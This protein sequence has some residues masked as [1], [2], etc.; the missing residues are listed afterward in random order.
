MNIEEKMKNIIVA[1]DFSEESERAV[2][3]AMALIDRNLDTTIH[4]IHVVKPY[5]A[6]IGDTTGTTEIL[7]EEEEDILK[8]SRNRIERMV[9]SLKNNGAKN[10][11]GSVR[12]GDPV[13]IIIAAVDEYKA[14][15]IVMGTRKHG[16][17][18]G[19]FTGSVSERVSANSP[20]SVLIVR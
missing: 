14:G 4:L 12:V 10:V 3:F 11:H 6:P 17:A 15:L 16:L 13:S 8:T 5:Y 19:I 20:V 9:T 18:K 2:E 7:Q 1:V